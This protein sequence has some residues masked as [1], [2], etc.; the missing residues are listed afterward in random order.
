MEKNI[1]MGK[2]YYTVGLV[3]KSNLKTVERDNIN[4]MIH[5]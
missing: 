4:T 3:P 1:T 5:V 2:K